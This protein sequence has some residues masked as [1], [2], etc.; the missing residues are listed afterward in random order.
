MFFHT[1]FITYMLMCFFGLGAI[2]LMLTT[3]RHS[4]SGKT[5][6]LI[7]T[8]NFAVGTFVLGAFYFFNYYR[9]LVM[10]VY[11]ANALLRGIDAVVF[12]GMGFS[13]L[14]LM[15]AVM[16]CQ[17]SSM[18]IW[19]K[20]TNILTLTFMLLSVFNYVFLLDEYYN[21]SNHGV[22]L[23]VI[24][25][26]QIMG[27]SLVVFTIV[28]LSIG[29]KEL[30]DAASRRYLLGT[31]ILVN[32]NN[33]WNN[34]IAIG[35][36]MG[37]FSPSLWTA[38]IY[39]LTSVF[40]LIINFITVIYA[41]KRDFSPLYYQ[42]RGNEEQGETLSEG[43]LINLVAEKHKLTEREREVLLLA[44]QGLTNPDI[45]EKLLISRYTVKRH[46][47]NLFEKLDVSTRMELIHLINSK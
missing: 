25:S 18:K 39:G 43:D 3:I 26:E 45:A 34:V 27:M 44:Y 21:A 12:Y 32:F 41:Y 23:Y 28:Y 7:T 36:F 33:V 40:L 47:H 29:Y 2:T 38:K 42:H 6:L 31:S 35:I 5:K 11:A 17:S 24:L 9:G 4:E 19:R 16:D 22:E 8:R 1:L 30:V 46:M 37:L 13:W 14:K 15:D 10:G 20:I